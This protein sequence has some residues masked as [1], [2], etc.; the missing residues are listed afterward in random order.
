MRTPV[1]FY[2][3]FHT[4]ARLPFKSI[5]LN[6]ILLHSYKRMIENLVRQDD[7]TDN[8]T[9]YQHHDSASYQQPM[10]LLPVNIDILNTLLQTI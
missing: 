8:A 5:A 7:L 1:A 10:K 4:T 2:F 3:T 6:C 9:L